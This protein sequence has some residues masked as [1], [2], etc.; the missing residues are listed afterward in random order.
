MPGQRREITGDQLNLGPLQNNGG[1]TFTMALGTGSVAIGAGNATISN[2]PPINGLDQRGFSRITSDIGAYAFS[3]LITVTTILDTINSTDGVT[4]L[5]E[6]INLANANAGPDIINF[7]ITGGTGVIQTIT[8]ATALPLIT[9]QVAIDGTTQNGYSPNTL[10]VGAG[11]NAA[12]KIQL[13]GSNF[14]AA[15]GIVGL[16]FNSP[17]S[18]VS[19]LSF[20]NFPFAIYANNNNITIKGNY[21]GLNADGTAQSNGLSGVGVDVATVNAAIVGGN[22]AADQNIFGNLNVGILQSCR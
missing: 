12:I 7:A 9:D 2:A 22:T 3:N 17:G 15:S 11:N 13:D 5:R 10:S 19:G 20:V 18:S 16:Y 21:F 14:T 1:P 6:A 4:S 8:L